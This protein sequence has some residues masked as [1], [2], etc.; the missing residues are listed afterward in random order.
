[1]RRNHN[2]EPAG[3]PKPKGLGLLI[4]IGT[5]I[6]DIG[7]TKAVNCIKTG[8]SNTFYSGGMDGKIFIWQITGDLGL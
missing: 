5:N 6:T 2:L 8:P 4:V 3:N 1:V 7:H